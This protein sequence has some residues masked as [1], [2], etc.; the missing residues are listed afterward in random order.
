MPKG[1][2]SVTADVV[3]LVSLRDLAEISGS[4]VPCRGTISV[5]LHSVE[6]VLTTKLSLYPR[7]DAIR[8]HRCCNRGSLLLLS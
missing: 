1:H 6:L 3:V 4:I 7:V 5:P 8:L 2:L